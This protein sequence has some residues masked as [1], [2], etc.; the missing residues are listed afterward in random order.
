MQTYCTDTSFSKMLKTYGQQNTK[1]RMIPQAVSSVLYYA[2]KIR[3]ERF[4][5]QALAS[6]GT[7][8]CAALPL[9]GTNSTAMPV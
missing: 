3:S 9:R 6:V 2:Y 7:Y 8:S 4:G 1:G 5:L